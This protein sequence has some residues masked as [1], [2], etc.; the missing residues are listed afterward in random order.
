MMVTRAG[1]DGRR[2]E[3]ANGVKYMLTEG[4]QSLGG[5]YAIEYKDVIL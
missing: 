4:N 5:G 1:G 2:M 3:R